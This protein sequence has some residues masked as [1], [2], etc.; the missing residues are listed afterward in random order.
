MNDVF[1]RLHVRPFRGVEGRSFGRKSFDD[2][3]KHLSLKLEMGSRDG[4]PPWSVFDGVKNI[5]AAPEVLMAEIS[6]AIGALESARA[7]ALLK[8]PSPLPPK[9]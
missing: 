9:K 3:T 5:H 4:K 8:S 1:V 6:S 7:T 2:F